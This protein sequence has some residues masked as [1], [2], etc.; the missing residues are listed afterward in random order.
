[1]NI[2]IKQTNFYIIFFQKTE[3]I[4]I[5]VLLTS[6]A[7]LSSSVDFEII[8]EGSTAIEGKHFTIV[9][10]SKTLNFTKDQPT[11]DIIVKTIDNST[12]DGDVSFAIKLNDPGD[13]NLG[14]SK[15]IN[16]KINDDE[17]PLLFIL[18]SLTAKGTS[19]YNGAEEWTVT[20]EKDATDLK[21]V[22]I[23]NFV[24]G[25][26]SPTSPIYGVVNDE[27][28]EIKIPVGQII[29]VST[30]YPKITLRGY[31]GPD[32]EE[33][34]PTGGSITGTIAPDGQITFVDEFGS[35]VWTN[36]DMTAG[37]GWYNIYQAGVTL[38]KQ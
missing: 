35:Y 19:Y 27:K 26:S 2:S 38:K 10:T 18:G 15:K 25:G 32:G 6:L 31:Y 13:V 37:A 11:Q 34:I 36:E 30:S 9:N 7:G 1:M 3:E 21:K 22:W 29:A 24:L 33:E 17:H 20:I 16:I 4:K 12:F 8:T 23:K 5:P 28:T 14:A